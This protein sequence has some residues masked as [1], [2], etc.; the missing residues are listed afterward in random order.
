MNGVHCYEL[1]G[2]IAFRNHAFI[3]L[4]APV[5]GPSLSPGKA[6]LRAVTT[7]GSNDLVIGE[8]H[9]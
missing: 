7:M 1:F 2:R 8:D 4:Y 3:Y 9:L 5:A 6:T